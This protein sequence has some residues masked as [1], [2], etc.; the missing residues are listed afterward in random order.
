M[1]RN[2]REMQAG[3]ILMPVQGSSGDDEALRLVCEIAKGSKRKV[4][5]LYVIKVGRDQPLDVESSWE[6]LKAEQVLRHLEELGRELKCPVEA[7]VLAAR[8]PGPAVVQE[9]MEKGIDLIVMQ[10]PYKKRFG[11]FSLGDTVPYVLKNAPCQVIVCRE[12][13]EA[14]NGLVNGSGTHP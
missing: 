2:G 5:V 10:M 6:T 4:F 12:A 7:N 9:A 1:A 8:D 13:I 14:A 3:R 11:S